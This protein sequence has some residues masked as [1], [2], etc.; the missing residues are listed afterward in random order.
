MSISGTIN[1]TT[2]SAAYTYD[3]LGRLTTSNQTSHASSAQRRFAYDRW[4]NRTSVWDAVSGG[5]QIQSVVLQQSGG[6]PT[7]R[8]TSVTTSG[9]TATY[10]YDAAG[11]V[12]N[13]GVRTY[14]FDAENRVVSV[15][16]GATASYGYDASNQRYKKATGGATTH[17]IWQASQVIA[18]HNGSTGAVVTE[19]VHSGSRMIANVSG[20][21]TQYLL[22]DRLSVRMTLNSS[23]N[24]LG[25]Q[26]H[27]P[28]GEDFGES[29]TQEKYHFSSYERSLK[30]ERT[31]PSIEDTMRRLE[32][33]GLQTRIAR[34]A[35]R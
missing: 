27:L 22:K 20:G 9:V 18:E 17:Y 14:T 23:G 25:R 28:F 19:Y 24:V 8:L 26:S 30:P 11:N 34:A 29:G 5:N 33:F 31:T 13:D 2:E 32:G 1:G 15:D 10:T 35:I 4:G 7:N 6:A 12:T 16:G 21:S 3:L